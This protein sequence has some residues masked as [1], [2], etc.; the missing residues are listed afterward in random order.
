MKYTPYPEDLGRDTTGDCLERTRSKFKDVEEVKSAWGKLRVFAGMDGYIDS[1]YSLVGKRD[2]VANFSIMNSMLEFSAKINDVA[3]S[4]CNIERVLK[5]R[6]GGGFGPNMARSI[7]TLGVEVDLMGCLGAPSEVFTSTLPENVNYYSLADP[8]ATCALEFNDG[9]IMITDFSNIYGVNWNLIE[10]KIGKENFLELM[11]GVDAIGQGHWA[12]V[13]FL[14]DIWKIWLE[15]IFPSMNK[16]RRIFFVDCADMSKRSNEHVHEMVNLLE[17]FNAIDGMRSIL[18]MNDKEAIQFS[19]AYAGIRE[20]Q[21]F[22]D[23]YTAGLD[24][25]DEFDIHAVVIHSPYFATV[26]SKE[27]T[28]HLKEGFTSKPRFTTAAGDHFNGAFLVAVAS[29]MFELDEAVLIANASTAHFVRT[30]ISPLVTDI[31][32]FIEHYKEYID[33]DIDVVI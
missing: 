32:G 4:S 11:N 8:G 33:G 24:M 7:G 31:K 15:E 22:S 6:L 25:I 23:Y 16:R 17:N 28:W 29:G 20:I 21:E 12:L 5:K 9:K 30:G 27:N 14:N 2:D 26:T 13:P 3:G 19:R 10:E 18:S 1:L